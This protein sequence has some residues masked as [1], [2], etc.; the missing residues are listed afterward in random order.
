[1]EEF[2]QQFL[3]AS[4][5]YVTMEEVRALIANSMTGITSP[6]TVK[7][8]YMQSA[9]FVSGSKGWRFDSI[10]NL[11]ANNGYFRGDITGANGTFSGTITATS[12]AI[13]GWAIAATA[14]SNGNMSI[15][16][17]TRINF[18][19]VFTVNASGAMTATSGTIGGWTLGATTISAT[20]ITLD[21]G[22]QRISVG[23]TSPILIDGANKKIESSNYVSGY[24]GSG[25]HIDENLMEV[26]NIACRGL[27]R[28]SVFQKDVIST[29]GGN[30]MVLDGDVLDRDMTAANMM[31][32][33][34]KGTTTFSTGDILRI[35][36]GENDEWFQVGAVA[37]P[38]YETA[39]DKAGAYADN[40]NPTWK[41]GATVV[42]YGQSGDGGLFMTASEANAPYLSVFT[43]AGS[44]WSSIT[45]RLR[46]GNLNGYLGYTTDKYGIG[47]GDTDNYL[48][49][50][51]TDKLQI[52]VSGT[53]ALKIQGGSNILLDG[54][55]DI[56]LT[57]V[58]EPTACTAT[59]SEVAGNVDAG[60]HTYKI[61]FVS[62]SGETTLGTVSNSVTNDGTNQQ[63]ELSD[64]P[65][66]ISNAITARRIYRNKAAG[67]SF[68]WYY[69]DEITDN[70]TTTYTDNT[71]DA[72][73]TGDG[74][75]RENTTFGKI[76]IDSIKAI[77]IGD[78]VTIGKYAGNDVPNASY[79]VFIGRMAGYHFRGGGGNV[80][81]GSGVASNYAAGIED[82]T[83]NVVIGLNR[84]LFGDLTGTGNTIIGAGNIG[85]STTNNS[86]SYNVFIGALADS[87]SSGSNKLV[88]GSNGYNLLFGEFDNQNF[89]INTI[90][91]ADGVR[92]IGIG[93]ASTVPTSNPSGGGILYV[94][95]GALKYRGSS[96]T[97]TTI[98][99]A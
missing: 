43:H 4:E 85:T 65:I 88:I 37:A 54:G 82:T 41:K 72:D 61:T 57:T 3:P 91:Y 46:I 5:K 68:N 90:D 9:D 94:Q 17:S 79:N 6:L 78:S 53:D 55:G 1:M 84:G 11:E 15:S 80:F 29:V 21:S 96:G 13:A 47:I 56:R 36:D 38:L 51:P 89:G 2:S 10:G 40:A 76:Y 26:G 31:N 7:S 95:S 24:A 42:N 74:T 58:T 27:I 64:I 45:T 92:V 66:S 50:D 25:F 18:N 83:A 12:G 63:V 16:S 81:I 28:T 32:I 60:A 49:F 67:G 87:S 73:L 99:N 62:S 20:S 22:N 93:N 70:T 33:M 8:S 59:L 30:L 98:A 23:A 44:P 97:V 48:K 35:K 77:D 75:Q 52:K 69:L 86:G 14:I 71:A 19:S 39:R 34:T